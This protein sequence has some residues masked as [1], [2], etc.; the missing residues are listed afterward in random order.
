M[1][2]ESEKNIGEWFRVLSLNW[3][4]RGK[5]SILISRLWVVTLIH[6][7]FGFDSQVRGISIAVGMMIFNIVGGLDFEHSLVRRC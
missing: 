4:A 1:D 6:I 3:L 2:R 5:H 7:K